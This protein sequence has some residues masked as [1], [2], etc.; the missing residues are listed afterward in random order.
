MKKYL[1][2]LLL[3]IPSFA[4]A[5]DIDCDS[6]TLQSA[7]DA[8]SDG[9]TITCKAGAFSW[10]GNVTVPD[11]KGL[12]LVG[13][14]TSL[15]TGTV[16]T[17]NGAYALTVETS[18]TNSQVTISNFRFIKTEATVLGMIKMRGD[19]TNWRIHSNYFDKQLK[20][21]H[22][23]S[24]TGYNYG[25]IDNNT[26]T[27]LTSNTIGV[28]W[29]LNASDKGA[30]VW[31]KSDMFSATGDAKAVYVENNTFLSATKAAE[32]LTGR[33]GSKVV[34]RYND[35]HNVQTSSHSGCTGGYMNSL[36]H[37]VYKNNVFTDS[38]Y[39]AYGGA[40]TIRLRSLSAVVWSNQST[41]TIPYFTIGIDNERSWRTDCADTYYHMNRICD[42]SQTWDENV[43][44]QSGWRCFGQPGWSA[45]QVADMTAATFR[46]TFAW[47]N[48]NNGT[49]VNL[50]ID[51]STAGASSTHL[52]FGRE[53]FNTANMTV[54]GAKP[55]TCTYNASTLYRDIYIDTTN[56]VKPVI[57]Q[58]SATNTW[59]QHW[60]PYTCP[61]PLAG[62]G[63]CTTAAGTGGYLLGGEPP[64]YTATSSVVSLTGG[65]VSGAQSVES[66]S[67]ATFTNEPFNGWKFKAWAGTCGCTGTG[68]CAPTI[69]ADCTVT[70]EFEQIYLNTF[71]R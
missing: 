46:G 3:L 26:F 33:G 12:K 54:G 50:R 24:I 70:A 40:S 31:A 7:I 66:G 67:T 56:S 2:L 61:H 25:L 51:N 18:S 41:S 37:E 34:W 15:D 1:V 5:A 42:G 47:D 11:T 28:E 63:E 69:T 48:T 68:A 32:A 44:G 8:A 59:T 49:A 9:G 43:T 38:N 21:G 71:C 13:A 23:I 60:T 10:T 45:P 57:W 20:A 39:S 22:A 65:T 55:E 62:A 52:K 14:G 36:W 17:L 53:L 27:N 30:F 16:I 4:F 64:I 58:C 19:A 29:A 6:T 35:L